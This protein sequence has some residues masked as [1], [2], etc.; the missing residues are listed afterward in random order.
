MS[1]NPCIDC[2]HRGDNEDSNCYFCKLDTEKRYV[3]TED[4]CVPEW[5]PL[6]KK[7]AKMKYNCTICG[8]GCYSAD[9]TKTICVECETDKDVANMKSAVEIKEAIRIIK[10]SISNHRRMKN[11]E[12]VTYCETQIKTLKWVLGVEE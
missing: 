12:L 1:R 6:V 5:C 2:E 10:E 7:G 4:K 11:W 9:E 8:V 3:F